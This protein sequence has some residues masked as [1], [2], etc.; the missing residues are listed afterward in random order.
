MSAVARV[1]LDTGHHGQA[2][3]LVKKAAAVNPNNAF[4]HY[5]AAHAALVSANFDDCIYHSDRVLAL[6]PF[7]PAEHIVRAFKALALCLKGEFMEAR[8]AYLAIN[9]PKRLNFNQRSVDALILLK[10]GRVEEARASIAAIK[11]EFPQLSISHLA[12]G[13]RNFAPN[14]VDPIL[15]GLRELGVPE[16]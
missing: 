1:L 15:K 6:S 2:M 14:F 3:A 9:N 4:V 7:D 8:E 10:L 16:E 11:A 12:R 5:R 13:N